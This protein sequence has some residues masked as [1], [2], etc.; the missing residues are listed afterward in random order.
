MST[1]ELLDRALQALVDTDYSTP[2]DENDEEFCENFCQS[3]G[4][5]GPR[6]ECW[7]HYI[8]RKG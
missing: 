1:A 2:C 6:K 8:E 7:L 5:P 3:F 4:E